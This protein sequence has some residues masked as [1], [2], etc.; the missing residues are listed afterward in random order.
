MRL[1][2]SRLEGT[3]DAEIL[4]NLLALASDVARA[5]GNDRIGLVTGEPRWTF[6]AE[7]ITREV[8]S[9]PFSPPGLAIQGR[10]PRYEPRTVPAA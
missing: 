4:A 6:V 9:S 1:A 5:T 8:E 3:P 7:A 10:F 2:H